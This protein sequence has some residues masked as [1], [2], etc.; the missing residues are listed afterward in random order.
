VTGVVGS[1]LL[2]AFSIPF[3]I[4]SVVVLGFFGTMIGWI[5]GV[6]VVLIGIVNGLFWSWMRAPTLKGRKLLDQIEGLR[7]YLT[8]A[9][10]QDIEQRHAKAPPQTFEE[11]ERLLPFAVALD[12]ADTWAKR[13]ANEIEAAARLG[14]AQ[15]RHW[16][17]ATIGDGGFSAASLGTALG[18][19]LA[20]A[21]ASASTA[22]GSSSGGGGGG[23]SGGGGGGGGGG[24]W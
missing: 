14:D 2:T 3:A 19:G 16:Y 22:P 9:E 18:A 17:P 6:I 5:P 10:R 20:S 15:S 1:V 8:V 13:F 12:A 23:F 24:G 4:A 11:F 7:L 21:T